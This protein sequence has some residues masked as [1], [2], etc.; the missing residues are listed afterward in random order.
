[1]ALSV[2]FCIAGTANAYL[3][4][5]LFVVSIDGVRD[6]EAF[7]YEFAPGEIEHPYLPFIW[8]ELKPQG[9]T[10]MEMYNICTT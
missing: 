8:N 10:Y 4:D 6:H 1:M 3:T 9:T 7:D 5:N 2:L